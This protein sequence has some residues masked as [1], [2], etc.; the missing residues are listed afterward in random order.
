MADIVS[1]YITLFQKTREVALN[2]IKGQNEKKAF[3]TDLDKFLKQENAKSIVQN[4]PGN[5]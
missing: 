5:I 4:N 2:Y 1:D 3:Q